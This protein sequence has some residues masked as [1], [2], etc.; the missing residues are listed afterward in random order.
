MKKRTLSLLLALTL[1]FGLLAGC[2][3]TAPPAAPAPAAAEPTPEPPVS[4]APQT[5]TV[6]DMAGR[7]VEVPAEINSI[8]TFGA[9]GV[10]NAF[11]ELMGAGDKLCNQMPPNFTKNDKWH[12]QYEFAPQI[13]NGPVLEN[14]DREILIEEVL[15]LQPDLC[16]TMTKSTAEYLEENGLTVLYLSW[17]EADDVKTAVELMGEALGAQDI[18]ADYIRYF[19]GTVSRAEALTGDLSDGERVK[20]LY[21]NVANLSQPHRIAEWWISA[22]GAVSV[23]DD[24]HTEESY[25][26]TTEDLLVWNPDVL[27]LTADSREELKADAQ[28]NG[29]SA[30]QNDAMYLVPTVAHTWGN[31][32]VEQPLTILWAVHK[33]YPELYSYEELA[34]DIH[35]FYDHFFL[36]DM[37]DEQIAEI[38]G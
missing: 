17:S 8:A 19:D 20:V 16:L 32:T 2:A 9:V 24:G 7:T 3:Q 10:L 35:G 23:S 21:G 26:Y 30:I 5:R 12:M 14:A 6:T 34:Q 36:Y 4:A 25:T 28:I 33:C 31:R 11:V 22:A 15:Q 38:I 29:I 37:T 13:A 27:L 18:A 1:L